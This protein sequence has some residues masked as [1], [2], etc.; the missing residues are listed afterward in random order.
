MANKEKYPNLTTPK[1]VENRFQSG[2]EAVEKGRKGGKK[3]V[4]NA[5]IRKILM[6][7]LQD[8]ANSEITKKIFQETGTQIKAPKNK[9]AVACAILLNA[10][11]GS[12]KFT[13][14]LLKIIGEMPNET[15]NINNE[16]QDE[17]LNNIVL[18]LKGV[19]YAEETDEPRNETSGSK[20]IK[21]DE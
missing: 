6:T 8:K 12:S 13:E 21:D 10:L 5:N 20:D 3:R 11:S 9:D 15:I 4:E 2:E 16:K 7:L 18:A 19:K 14:L 1:A 17:N